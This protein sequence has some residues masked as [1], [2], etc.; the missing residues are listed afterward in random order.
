MNLKALILLIAGHF[1]ADVSTGALPAFLP[2]I[3]ESLRLSY[4]ATASIILIFSLTSSVIQPTFGYLSDRRSAPWLLPAGCLITSLGMA[5]LGFGTSYAWIFF[6]SALSGLG[7]GGFHPEGFKTVNFMGGEKKASAISLF[8]VGGSLGVSVGP[9]M[10][11]LFFKYFGLKG[12]V[13]FLPLGILIAVIFMV[14]PYWKGKT[15]HFANKGRGLKISDSFR[16][17]TLPIALLVLVVVLRSA[18][19][20]SL[21]T[22]IPFYFI[23]VLQRDPLVV[24]QYL[25]TFLLAGTFG[26]LVGGPLADRYGYKRSVLFC[27]I[28]SPIFL[29]LFFYTEGTKSLIFFALAGLFLNA[30]HAVNMAMG[31]AYMPQNLGMASGLILG[32]AM[33]IGGIGTTILGWIADQRSLYATLN[34]TFVLP[35]LGLLLFSFIPYPPKD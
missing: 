14:T 26:S 7:Q 27:L 5:L 23:D 3:K 30:P 17:K 18:T 12:S 1:V 11:T 28:F 32:L 24:G 25:S 31:Q 15:E 13:L 33:G 6:F 16:G 8:L 2:F 34:I 21:Q 9:L 10:A 22:F 35:L 20:L 29:Y 4:T 19:Q